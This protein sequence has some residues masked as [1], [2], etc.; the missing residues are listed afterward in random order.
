MK[1][2]ACIGNFDGVHQGHQA[3][4][5][6][7]IELSDN[8]FVPTII[9]FDPD[10]EVIFSNEEKKYL[11]T[12]KQKKEYMYNFGIKEII[13]IPFTKEFSFIDK[14]K[15]ID[16]VLNK[17]KLDTLICGKDFRFGYKGKGNSDYLIKSE[18]KNFKVEVLE[19]IMFNGEKISSTLIGNL[20]REG[21]L[22]LAK[23]L[24]NHDY[25]IEASILN[26]KVNTE[27][28]IPLKGE[29]KVLINS[30]KYILKNKTINYP[31]EK[32]VKIVFI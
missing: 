19:H 10:P 11:T 16:D 24:L 12:L 28:I 7:V 31:D 27:N 9:T 26:N 14:E 4:I 18:K 17:L 6:K 1:K 3:L 15:F 29:S 21:N 8:K 23:I 25:Y 22:D 20:I 13:V 32:K 2:V 5:K 30:K